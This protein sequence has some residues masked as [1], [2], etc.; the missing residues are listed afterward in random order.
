MSAGKLAGCSFFESSDDRSRL[1]VE[2]YLQKQK[3]GSQL[4]DVLDVV[5]E[6]GV[7]K[8]SLEGH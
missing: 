7:F 4:D 8:V 2:W 3:S 5:I 1:A 6:T